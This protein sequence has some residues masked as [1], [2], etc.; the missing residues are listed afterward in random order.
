MGK[1]TPNSRGRGNSTN[2]MKMAYT[3]QSMYSCSSI[4][5]E[6]LNWNPQGQ[7]KRESPQN[8]WWQEVER[9][10]KRTGYTWKQLDMIAVRE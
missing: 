3:M 1:D 6:A 8:T 9:D 7:R 5:H 4:G 10:I 2:E